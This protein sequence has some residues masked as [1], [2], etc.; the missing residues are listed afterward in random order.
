MERIQAAIAK[1]RATRLGTPATPPRAGRHPGQ[2][3]PDRRQAAWEALPLH[4]PDPDLLEDARIVTGDNGPE[5]AAF[6]VMRT[7]A[8]KLM[9]ANGWTR[10]AITSPSAACGKSTVLLNLGYSLTRRPD[11][12]AILVEADMR[13]PSLARKLGLAARYQTSAVLRGAS[14]FEHNAC[15]LGDRLALTCNATTVANP[16]D[17]LQAPEA[18]AALDAI[19]AAYAPS[20]MLFDMPPLMANDDTIGFLQNVDCAMLVAAADHS[21][22]REIDTCERELAAHTN[23]LGVVL[24][25][26]RFAGRK[27]GYDYDY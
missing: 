11:I 16:S 21:T 27:Y 26:C 1:A 4:Q 17:L 23:V 8:L 10:M 24:N 18:T 9:Q 13:R 25:K 7:R 5:G 15:R 14:P 19:E 6:D 20:L 22:A 12:S 3:G 2:Q